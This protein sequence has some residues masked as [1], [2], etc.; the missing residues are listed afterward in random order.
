LT[1]EHGTVTRLATLHSSSVGPQGAMSPW[2]FVGRHPAGVTVVVKVGQPLII[3]L[4]IVLVLPTAVLS[5]GEA[6]SVMYAVLTQPPGRQ[7]REQG[8]DE[9]M[10][11]TEAGQP[12]GTVMVKSGMHC[13]T[14]HV[15]QCSCLVMVGQETRDDC[16]AANLEIENIVY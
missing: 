5:H 11:G 14:G 12:Q 1:H 8:W 6:A 16:A 4:V 9:V 13:A 3:L 7:P 15:E 10:V 2:A